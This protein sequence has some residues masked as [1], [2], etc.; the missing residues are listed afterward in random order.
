MLHSLASQ[1]T[2]LFTAQAL[3]LTSNVTFIAINA[4][5]GAS[6]ASQPMLATLPIA[7]QALA[8]AVS[9][10]PSS[11][12]MAR[13]G[14]RVGFTVGAC[15]G[16]M[17]SLVAAWGMVSHS[18][19][20]LCVGTFMAGVYNGMGQYLRFAAADVAQQFKPS[21]KAQAIAIVLAGGGNWRCGR[22]RS[23]QTHARRDGHC[24]LSDVFEF[25]R[26]CYGCTHRCAMLTS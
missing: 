16:I 19:A 3:L 5:A 23:R 10:Y 7:M 17:G 1:M 15:F 14:R 26:F 25:G 2:V 20:L 11:L 21:F 4:L 18:L 13:F 9:S 8:S 24:F 6:L 22:P 12:L